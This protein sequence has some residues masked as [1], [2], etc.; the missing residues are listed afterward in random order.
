V[1][2]TDKK[3]IGEEIDGKGMLEEQEVK[4]TRVRVG[5]EEYEDFGYMV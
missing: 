5:W 2:D 1:K 4:R 3:S